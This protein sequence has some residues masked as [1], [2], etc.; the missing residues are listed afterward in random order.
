MHLHVYDPE[1]QRHI[2]KCGYD[3]N[4]S[5]PS[6]LLSLKGVTSFLCLA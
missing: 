1:L 4:D 6:Q 5:D 3:D 2:L